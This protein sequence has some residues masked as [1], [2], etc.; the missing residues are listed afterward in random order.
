MRHA[1][2]RAGQAQPAGVSAAELREWLA[3]AIADPV[4]AEFRSISTGH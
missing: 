2:G 4:S 1:A 3:A